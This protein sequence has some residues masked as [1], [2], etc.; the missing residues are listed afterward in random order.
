[1]AFEDDVKGTRDYLVTAIKGVWGTTSHEPP[2]ITTPNPFTQV[3]VANMSFE[4][5]S[6]S[7]SDM[8]LVTFV[9]GGSFDASG[10]TNDEAIEKIHDARDAILADT[11]AGGFATSVQLDQADIIDDDPKDGEYQIVL[12]V[13]AKISADRI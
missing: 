10:P 11:H 2:K 8:A 1:M 6:V 13:S 9:I 4:P 3:V 7:S 12:Q 5:L